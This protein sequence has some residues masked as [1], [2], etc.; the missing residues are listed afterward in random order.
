MSYYKRI[1]DK[2][3]CKHEWNFVCDVKHKDDFGGKYTRR[4]FVCVNC[5][6]FK[7]IKL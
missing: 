3:C 7:Q 1:I 2:L 4:T 6:K 5:G